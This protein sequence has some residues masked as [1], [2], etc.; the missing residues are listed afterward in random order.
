MK[1]LETIKSALL[2]LLS[3]KLRSFLTMLGVIIGVFAVVALVSL[4][5]GIE[6]FI[7]D[8]FNAIGSNLIIVVPGRAGLAQDP[9]LSF[10]KKTLKE[11]HVDLIRDE[12]GE[13]ILG[14]TPSIR[15]VKK[16]QY[17]T[18]DHI[19]TITASNSEAVELFNTSIKEGRY[20]NR[21]EVKNKDY[22]AV[23]APEV[24]D[25]LFGEID[26]IGKK[27]KIDSKQFTVIGL[28]EDEGGQ[29]NERVFVPYTTAQ[30]VFEVDSITNILV[31][32]ENS[33][34]VDDLGINI[35][36]SLAKEMDRDDFTVISQNEILDSAGNILDILSI[37]LAAIAGISLLV[38]GIGIMNI[39]L[40]TVNERIQEI[41]LRKALGATGF[42]IGSQFF[43][44]ALTISLLGGFLGLGLSWILTIAISNTIRAEITSWV[45]LLAIGF[46]LLVGAVFGTYPAIK[47]AKKDPIEALRHE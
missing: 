20:F 26:P 39:M 34:N 12:F 5:T 35:E 29:S 25:E 24:R 40:V 31:K 1:H 11:K 36:H 18:R 42:D 33:Q 46:S 37:I 28:I 16:T 45:V 47:A 17:K 15:L 32:G 4:V 2:S 43:V 38:G 41:G 3:N 13:V 30:E 27:I 14:V 9:A 10:T 21:A 23:L 6:N 19:S 8:R 44:E 22:V 7:V